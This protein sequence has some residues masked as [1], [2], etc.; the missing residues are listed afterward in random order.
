MNKKCIL[1]IAIISVMVIL[2]ST[3]CNTYDA[4][5]G[6]SGTSGST[7]ISSNGREMMGSMIYLTFEDAARIATDVVVV[8]YVARRPF[9]DSLTEFEFIVHERIFGNAA[10][11]I[12]VYANNNISVSVMGTD[13]LLVGNERQFTTDAQ[14][15]L[16]L[17]KIHLRCQHQ[18][19]IVNFT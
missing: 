14:Y 5:I 16:L 11:R 1:I 19:D 9:G 7:T 17:D 3:A 6:T 8:Q 12:F 2:T 13:G 10:D 18:C 4:Q 15:L